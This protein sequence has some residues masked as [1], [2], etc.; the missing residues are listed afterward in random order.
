MKRRGCL[1]TVSATAMLL[2][3]ACARA[4]GYTSVPIREWTPCLGHDATGPDGRYR[5]LMRIDPRLPAVLQT[6]SSSPKV[7]AR[8]LFN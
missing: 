1:L 3:A 6:A 8:S 4:G 5:E 7:A 2:M